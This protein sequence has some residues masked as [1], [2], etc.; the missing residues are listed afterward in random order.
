VATDGPLVAIAAV[1][2]LA[3]CFSTF[4][5]PAIGALIPSLVRDETEFGP[6]NS[7]WATLDNFAWIVGPGIAGVLLATG[8]IVLAFVLNAITFLVIAVILWTLPPSKPDRGTAAPTAIDAPASSPDAVPTPARRGRFDDLVEA[9]VRIPA[10]VGVTLVSSATWFAF[11]G[12]GI[13]IVVIAVDVFSGGDAATGYLNAAIGIGGTIGALLSAALVLRPRLGRPLLLGALA[14]GGAAVLLGVANSL[15]VA[16]I[17]I[18]VASIGNLVTDVTGT[19]IFQRAVPDA[20]RGRFSGLT[21]T[22]QVVAETAGTLLVPILV[23]LFGFGPVFALLGGLVVVATFGA[24]VLIG[25]AADLAP[26]PYDGDLRRLARLP[27]FGGLSP[28]QVETALRRLAPIE[29]AAGDVI[30][31]EGDPADRFY[32][33]CGGTF[34]VWKTGADGERV[35]VNTL[36]DDDVFGERGLIAGSPRTASVTCATPGRLF[37]MEGPDFLELIGGRQGVR[38]R[39]MALYD[40]PAE[41]MGRG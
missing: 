36:S 19:T 11:G 41:T 25:P 20:Y 9:G 6:A 32:V 10:V 15:L 38:D 35:L 24:V 21:M 1:A 16:F 14:M 2:M 28:G 22:G 3:A 31:R 8:D 33:I 27:L 18:L 23:S 17:A 29:A 13:L 7:A 37:A 30:I 34:E 39:L 5:Y 4:F 40:S 26:S 12:I